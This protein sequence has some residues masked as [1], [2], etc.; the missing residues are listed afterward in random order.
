MF[1]QESPVDLLH[2]CCMQSIS[3]L[4]AKFLTLFQTDNG[5]NKCCTLKK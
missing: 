5:Y 4:N 3:K 1:K 2:T